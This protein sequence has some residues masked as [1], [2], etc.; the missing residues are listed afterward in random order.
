MR[1]GSRSSQSNPLKYFNHS[2][3]F[4]L[5]NIIFGLLLWA[6]PFC[7]FAKKSHTEKVEND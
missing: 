7:P 5:Y 6:A 1:A 3:L 4:L 2:D